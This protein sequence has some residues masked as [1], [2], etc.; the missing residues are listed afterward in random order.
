MA[1]RERGDGP[2]RPAS[3]DPRRGRG[4]RRPAGSGLRAPAGADP[5]RDAALAAEALGSGRLRLALQPVRPATRPDRLCFREALARVETP[6]GALLSASR[7]AETLERQGL[8]PALDRA[9]LALTMG[10]LRR[11]RGARLSVNVSATT[12]GDRRWSLLLD[13]AAETDPDA[14]R[15]LIV[16]LT[17]TARADPAAA[18]AFRDRVA[19]R[20]AAFA[21]DDFGAGHADAEAARALRPDVLKLDAGLCADD[22]AVAVAVALAWELEA[23][24]VAE[25][26]ERRADA[27]RLAAL[28]IDALQGRLT[29]EPVCQAA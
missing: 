4:A 22:A 23:M 21:L 26:V 9:A 8:A 28:G 20:G 17:E 5:A 27:L 15:R 25:G 3:G 2:G 29:G 1:D 6:D 19:A 7:F 16:E 11:D 18:L 12:V 14:A 13:A 10:L 24:T